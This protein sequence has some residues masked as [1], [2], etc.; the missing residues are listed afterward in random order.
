MI[1]NMIIVA[2]NVFTLL[3]MM[4]LGFGLA[5]AG[6][7]SEETRSQMTRILLYIV[8]PCIIITNMPDTCNAQTLH[9]FKVTGLAFVLIYLA[10]AAVAWFLFRGFPED[11]RASLNSAAV[12]GNALF[13]GLPLLQSVLGDEALLYGVIGSVVINIF[14]WTHG[15][16]IMGGK[17]YISLKKAILNPG[18]LGFTTGFV[19]FLSGIRL[20]Q[21]VDRAMVFLSNLNTPLAMLVIG[22][23]M[24]ATDILRTFLDKKLYL[25]SA[26]R[27]IIFPAAAMLALL[28]FHLDGVMYLSIVIS[29]GCPVAAAT[30]MFAQQFGRDTRTAS[31]SI[32]QSTLLC[33]FTMPVLTAAARALAGI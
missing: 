26:L 8:T 6:W 18:V 13:M 23:Q 9:I 24:A 17:K 10:Y 21:P 7:F 28:P 14:T 15:V 33:I 11:T 19:L 31:Q 16:A 27:L 2:G 1:S 30:G 12:Y 29:V 20:P 3:L 4:L 22:A 32:A 25:I 5:K